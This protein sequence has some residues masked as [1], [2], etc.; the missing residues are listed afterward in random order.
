MKK[1]L[2]D[3]SNAF[4]LIQPEDGEEI[5]EIGLFGSNMLMQIMD[6][7]KSLESM[8]SNY[9]VESFRFG[10]IVSKD[11]LKLLAIQPK[12]LTGSAWVVLAPRG[13]G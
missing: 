10:F 8:G 9:D 12:S 11:G 13:E 6:F 1:L 7:C 3:K 5:T 2:T 4:G